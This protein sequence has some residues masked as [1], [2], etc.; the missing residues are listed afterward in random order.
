M[1][2][3][4]AGMNVIKMHREGVGILRGEVGEIRENSPSSHV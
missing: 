1:I 3:L 2:D 4:L